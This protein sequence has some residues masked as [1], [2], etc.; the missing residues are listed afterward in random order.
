MHRLQTEC[1]LIK[2]CFEKWFTK[3]YIAFCWFVNDMRQI[4][5]K[6]LTAIE[7]G[8]D[9]IGGRLPVKWT[10]GEIVEFSAVN[11]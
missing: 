8:V 6:N 1:S 9:I 11:S 2:N 7:E 10:H 5:S 3:Q 4:K